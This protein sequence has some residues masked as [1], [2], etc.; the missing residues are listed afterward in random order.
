MD[1]AKSSPLD[2]KE[3]RHRKGL[4]S[5]RMGLLKKVSLLDATPE[6]ET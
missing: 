5:K 2:R 3:N 6:E 1:R 4:E